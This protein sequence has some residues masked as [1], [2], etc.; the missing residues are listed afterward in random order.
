MKIDAKHSILGNKRI[1]Q[2]K[3]IMSVLYFKRT[4]K[5]KT[6]KLVYME[7]FPRYQN[8]ETNE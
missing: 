1:L 8:A 5:Q 3:G 6:Q 2:E 7:R 4:T